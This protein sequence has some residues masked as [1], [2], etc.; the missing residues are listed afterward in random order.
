[1]TGGNLLPTILPKTT[2][3]NPTNAMIAMNT[4]RT[5]PIAGRKRGCEPLREKRQLASKATKVPTAIVIQ[6]VVVFIGCVNLSR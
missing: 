6:K 4:I 1:M 2:A 3:R 5:T